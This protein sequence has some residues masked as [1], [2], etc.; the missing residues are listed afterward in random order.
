[1]KPRLLVLV[2]DG[3]A[4]SPSIEKTSLSIAK[5]P[6][7]DELAQHAYAG[8]HYPIGPGKA[9]ESDTAVLSLLGY[10]PEKYY[11]GRGPLEALGINVQIKEGYE[12]AFRANFATVNESTLEIV[13]RRVGRSLKTEEARE[14]A[15]A[16]DGMR[17]SDDG[18]AR[19]WATIGHRAVVVIGS[20]THRLSGMVGNTDPAYIRKGFI[21]IAVPNPS[22][23]IAKCVPLI[24]D[25]A[26][27]ETCKLVN[28]FTLK[29]IEVLKNHP[30]NVERAKRGLPKANAILLRDAGDRMPRLPHFAKMHGFSSAGG[31]A[32]M[33]VEIGILRAASMRLYLVP[34]PTGNLREDLPLRL[35]TTIK[36]LSENDFVYVHLKGPDEPGHD[37]KFEGK[38]EA[39]EQIDR[40]FIQPLLNEIDLE[41][42]AILVTSDHATPYTLRAHSGD[43]VPFMLSWKK[44]GNSIGKFDEKQC[45][46]QAKWRIDYA[47]K[48]LPTILE[49]LR[50][51]A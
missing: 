34:P 48:L 45:I 37:G 11:T 44:I 31:I 32:E 16:V 12:V 40:Y 15:K 7:L 26:A 41:K 39:I 3:A 28:E 50:T 22:K 42:V 51:H 18:Y 2:L 36:A 43:P 25:K 46:K 29:A 27:K 6:G 23:Q 5:T 1:M 14:L 49:F 10:N 21:S 9:P 47:Y 4:D 8:F 20:R 13:D 33:P 38:V 24:D 35:K 30:I 19:V 17:L